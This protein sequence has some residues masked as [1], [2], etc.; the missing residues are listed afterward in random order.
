MDANY[1]PYNHFR[2]YKHPSYAITGSRLLYTVQ[3]GFWLA[4]YHAV[5]VLIW[6]YTI[7]VRFAALTV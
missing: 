1:G 2:P 6:P 7:M 5:A 4:G 3:Y